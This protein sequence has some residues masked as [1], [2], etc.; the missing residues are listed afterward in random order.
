MSTENHL[1]AMI[2]DHPGGPARDTAPDREPATFFHNDGT[3]WLVVDLPRRTVDG[4]RKLAK[5]DGVPVDELLSEAIVQGI[6]DFVEEHKGGF[7]P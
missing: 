7:R 5:R 2:G 4:Y 1:A 6:S 3:V